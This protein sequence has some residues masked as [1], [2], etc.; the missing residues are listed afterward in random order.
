MTDDTMTRQFFA[1][2][3]S[4]FRLGADDQAVLAG[5]HAAAGEFFGHLPEWKAAFS[6]DGTGWQAYGTRLAGPDYPG[7]RDLCERFDYWADDPGRIPAQ[8]EIP[9]LTSALHAWWQVAARH[10]AGILAGLSAH[11]GYRH[12]VEFAGTSYL[13]VSRYGTP[14]G[15]VPLIAPHVDGHLLTLVAAD[16]AGLEIQVAGT[17]TDAW[18]GPGDVLVLPGQLMEMMTGGRVP[19]LFHRVAYRGQGGRQSVMLFVNP[20][21]SRDIPTFAGEQAGIAEQARRNNTAFGQS[22]P[23]GLA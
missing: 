10:T 3:Y 15:P 21:F 23:A 14:D 7:Q 9:K 12:A 2:G 11:Y 22:I 4:R 1:E 18:A 13:E 8:A 20:P 17:M 6:G 5:L 16:K 19:G